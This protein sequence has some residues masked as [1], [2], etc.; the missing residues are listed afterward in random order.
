MSPKRNDEVDR[1]LQTHQQTSYRL[2]PDAGSD[3][4]ENLRRARKQVELQRKRRRVA[5]GLEDEG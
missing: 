1:D 4:M 2:P 5:T 3:K